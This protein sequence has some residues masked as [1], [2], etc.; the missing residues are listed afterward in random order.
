[1]GTWN[2]VHHLKYTQNISH[3]HARKNTS[4]RDFL[5]PYVSKQKRIKYHTITALALDFK[6][7]TVPSVSTQKLLGK[8]IIIII[9]Q[10]SVP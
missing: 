4:Y 2:T 6:K 3:K 5:T 9:K 1:M 10:L 8:K 7:F